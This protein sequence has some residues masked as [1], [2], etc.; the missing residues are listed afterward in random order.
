MLMARFFS[1]NKPC[2]FLSLPFKGRAGVG[3][4][5]RLRSLLHSPIPHLT[6]PCAK[7]TRRGVKGEEL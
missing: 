1:D 3:M 5:S 2:P 6:S 4:G 7:P